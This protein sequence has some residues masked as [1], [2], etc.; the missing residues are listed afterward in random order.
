MIRDLMEEVYRLHP[1]GKL[2]R[3]KITQERAAFE[4]YVD[5]VSKRYPESVQCSRLM[6]RAEDYLK[7]TLQEKT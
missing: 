3:R 1:S 4:K 2:M 5:A 6:L 7:A